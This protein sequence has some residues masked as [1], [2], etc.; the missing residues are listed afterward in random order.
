MKAGS[1]FSLESIRIR[2][3]L[4]FGS[5][6]S[7]HVLH[8]CTVIVQTL[9]NFGCIDGCRSSNRIKNFGTGAEAEN[10]TPAT[11]ATWQ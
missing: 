2:S 4:I 9:L 10:A 5:S 7:L 3:H 1:V 8:K 6:W 11:S